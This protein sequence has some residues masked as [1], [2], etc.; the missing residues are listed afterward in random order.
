VKRSPLQRRTAI[1]RTP[2]PRRLPRLSNVI[3]WTVRQEVETRSG[4]LCEWPSAGRQCTRGA[5]RHRRGGDGLQ[6][7]ITK[8][9]WTS[10]VDAH[11]HSPG[12]WNS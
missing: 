4:G 9:Q 1:R 10:T 7:H 11:S 12:E 5:C 3:P 8:P 6:R 2:F